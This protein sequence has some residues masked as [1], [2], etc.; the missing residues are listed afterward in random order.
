MSTI[1]TNFLAPN[2]QRLPF[3]FLIYPDVNIFHFFS[4][5]FLTSSLPIPN[6]VR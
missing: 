6:S 4:E 1:T 5:N 2:Q 3:K